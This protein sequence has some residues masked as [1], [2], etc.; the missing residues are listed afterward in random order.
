VQKQ[1][2]EEFKDEAIRRAE[3]AGY[4]PGASQRD[5]DWE[6][7][8]QLADLSKQ[9]GHWNFLSG[10]ELI[11]MGREGANEVIDNGM[12]RILASGMSEVPLPQGMFL[13]LG[14][15]APSISWSN[16]R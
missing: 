5:V 4:L 10:H 9:Y 16:V 6:N 15:P 3:A 14:Y 1:C 2:P 8:Q 13:R 7:V 12:H 11:I